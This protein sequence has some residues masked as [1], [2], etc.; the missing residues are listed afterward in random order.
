MREVICI[1]CGKPFTTNWAN[2]TTCSV[3]CRK[4]KDR[5][6][7][8]ERRAEYTKPKAPV[9]KPRKKKG[10]KPS[11]LAIINAKARKAGMTYGQYVASTAFTFK[12]K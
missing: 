4:A 6:Y 3:E 8:R 7:A 10:W 5:E 1:A 11:E 9:A 2:Q 12:I